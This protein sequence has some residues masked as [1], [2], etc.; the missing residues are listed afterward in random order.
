MKDGTFHLSP[1]ENMLTI[2]QKTFVISVFA[3]YVNELL[4]KFWI[5]IFLPKPPWFSAR[6]DGNIKA[7]ANQL[8]S[9]RML[10]RWGCSS[11]WRAN[12]STS[13]SSS[14]RSN[15][16]ILEM[17]RVNGIDIDYKKEIEK[18]RMLDRLR[19]YKTV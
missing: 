18:W 4:E 14:T 19:L 17:E 11:N 13:S 10:I 5:T 16:G 1:N 12:T 9:S 7:R 3:I 2:A 15:N 6:T 8:T